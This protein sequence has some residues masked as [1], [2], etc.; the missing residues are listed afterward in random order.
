MLEQQRRP[1]F[2]SMLA[3]PALM[4]GA[5]SEVIPNRLSLRLVKV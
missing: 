5:R 3:N 2:L 1:A 4:S